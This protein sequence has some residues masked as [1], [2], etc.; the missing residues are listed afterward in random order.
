[1]YSVSILPNLI[2]IFVSYCS[3]FQVY[4]DLKEVS[5]KNELYMLCDMAHLNRDRK[6]HTLIWD[7]TFL[8]QDYVTRYLLETAFPKLQ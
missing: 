1:M 7:V 8:P 6:S 2:I 4:Y 3:W 5:C